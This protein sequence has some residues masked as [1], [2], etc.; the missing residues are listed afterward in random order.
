MKTL[1]QIE[2]E[3]IKII[4]NDSIN[5]PSVLRV[6]LLHYANL[7]DKGQMLPS[8][9]SK[10]TECSV[11]WLEKNNEI[12]GGICSRKDEDLLAINIESIFYTDFNIFK[13][14][15]HICHKQLE[16][17]SK[18]QGY[19]HISI[20]SHVSNDEYINLINDVGMTKKY[21]FLTQQI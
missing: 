9:L 3:N 8:T 7:L 6:I 14:L 19:D 20:C 17:Y 5:V 2:S 10:M 21:Y 1:D 13:N 12:I 18:D 16:L 15:Y 4:F 11:I